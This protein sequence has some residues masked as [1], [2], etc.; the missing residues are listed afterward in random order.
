MLRSLVGSEMCIRDRSTGVETFC[1]MDPTSMDPIPDDDECILSMAGKADLEV[2]RWLDHGMDRPVDLD[3]EYDP[4]SR[5][6]STTSPLP[7]TESSTKPEQ[8]C[9]PKA[10]PP[11]RNT[12]PHL[13]GPEF[14]ARSEKAAEERRSSCP[15][16]SVWRGPAKPKVIGH[17]RDT[18][19]YSRWA[20][21]EGC[22][23][24][25]DR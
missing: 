13:L 20:E 19:V 17:R 22:E 23:A 6:S 1:D 18:C 2:V 10:A 16:L 11:R 8:R 14:G 7:P 25:S 9:S 12:A 24:E 15:S 4:H 3:S 5:K 21:S